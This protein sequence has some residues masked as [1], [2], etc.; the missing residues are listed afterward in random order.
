MS[1]S[2]LEFMEV[3]QFERLGMPMDYVDWAH[4]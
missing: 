4:E 1:L 2:M 3:E